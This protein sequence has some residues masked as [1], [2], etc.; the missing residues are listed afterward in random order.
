MAS[1]RC[2]K[3]R[4]NIVVTGEAGTV[5]EAVDEADRTRPDVVVMDVQLA[6]GSGI[7]AT[8]EIRADHPKTAVVMLTSRRWI[9]R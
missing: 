2:C 6:D 7:E 9:L 1:R 3:R 5:R 4:T 8:R